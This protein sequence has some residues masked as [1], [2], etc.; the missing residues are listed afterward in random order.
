[1]TSALVRA[2]RLYRVYRTTSREYRA[3]AA[4]LG[5]EP[6]DLTRRFNAERARTSDRRGAP[7]VG[8]AARNTVVADQR[9]TT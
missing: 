3:L 6:G 2:R 5:Y 9:E 7:L 1:M 8:S 4:A